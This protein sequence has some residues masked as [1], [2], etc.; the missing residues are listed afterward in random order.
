MRASGAGAQLVL[1]LVLI[2]A[3]LLWEEQPAVKCNYLFSVI[4]IDRQ[5]DRQ[6]D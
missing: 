3:A 6:T 5:T 2:F 1:L 4:I